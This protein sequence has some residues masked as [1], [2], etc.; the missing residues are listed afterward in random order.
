MPAHSGVKLSGTWV[1]MYWLLPI[2]VVVVDTQIQCKLGHLLS[3]SSFQPSSRLLI[4]LSVV[5]TAQQ[6][7]KQQNKRVISHFITVPLSHFQLVII[8]CVISKKL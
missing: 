1:L 7:D 6:R 5:T 2:A 4:E 3:Q 8:K